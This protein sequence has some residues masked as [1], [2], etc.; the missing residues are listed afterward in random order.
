MG[1]SSSGGFV[2]LS[3]AMSLMLH[4]VIDRAPTRADGH[5]Q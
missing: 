2:G 4:V 5:I 3:G 1:E